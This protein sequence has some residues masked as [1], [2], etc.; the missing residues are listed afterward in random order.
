MS[1]RSSLGLLVFLAVVA[2]LTWYEVPNRQNGEGAVAVSPPEPATATA[3]AENKTTAPA[4]ETQV[5]MA[6]PDSTVAAPK[7][8]VMPGPAAGPTFDVVRVEPTGEAVLAGQAEPKATVE[9]LDGNAP[10]ATTKSDVTGAW[11]MTLD[12]PLEPGAHDLGLRAT[13]EDKS[14]ATLSDERVTVSVP[15]KG[16]K[17]V[18][19]V[20]NTPNAPS[21]VLEVPGGNAPASSAQPGTGTEVANVAPPEPDKAQPEKPI[22]SEAPAASEAPVAAEAPVA[23]EAPV[24]AEPPVVTEA[25]VT[26]EPKVAEAPPAPAPEVVVG[27]VEADTS[28]GLYVGG[29]A[30][31]GE[32]VRI[33][34]NDKPL[35]E[36]TPTAA[37]TWLVQGQRD[38]PAGK[39]TVRADQ[40]DASGKVVARSEVPFEREVDVADL[41]P[42]G[43]AGAGQAGATATGQVTMETVV[44]KRGDNLWRIARGAWGNGMRWTTIYQANNDQI[45][46]PHWIYPGQIFIMP[47]GDATWT[48]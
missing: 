33:Y 7:T 30:K 37:G 12:K 41:K 44:I 38:L 19:V 43:A 47:K 26:A 2:L 15:D 39:Y 23:S 21:K 8:E 45:R 36:S 28:G 3:S 13:P 34:L 40:V 20:M 35:G 31:T 11:A 18:L 17:D 22:A 25:P 5:A 6:S 32:T 24:A 1:R 9:V 4:P 27:A 48:E 14:T 10:I 42:S 46:N 29:T 16:S